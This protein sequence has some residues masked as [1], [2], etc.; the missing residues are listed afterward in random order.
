MLTWFDVAGERRVSEISFRLN[1]P[2]ATIRSMDT[3]GRMI[4]R[5]SLPPC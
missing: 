3:F 1:D 5:L 2:C 4:V